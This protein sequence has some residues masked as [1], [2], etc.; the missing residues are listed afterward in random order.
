MGSTIRQVLEIVYKES[1]KGGVVISFGLALP[2]GSSFR[3]S[4][5]TINSLNDAKSPSGLE[6]LP[7]VECPN[8]KALL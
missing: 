7:K 8:H 5:P 6:T 2:A 4:Y 3:G 1:D